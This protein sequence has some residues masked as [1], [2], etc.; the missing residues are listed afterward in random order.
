MRP[1]EKALEYIREKGLLEKRDVII[2]GVSGGADSMCMLSI[3]L[4]LSDE[5]ELSITVVH[6]N[7]GIRGE[8]AERDEGFVK[9]FCRKHDVDF[10]AFH[11]DIPGMAEKERLTLEEAGRRFRYSAFEK[12]A[13]EKHAGKVAVAHNLDDNAETVMFNIFRG[14]GLAGICGIRPMR[15][16]NEKLDNSPMLIRP[17]LGLSRREIEAY[18]ADKGMTY[19]T[20]ETNLQND[21]S[22]NRIRNIILPEAEAM[23]NGC[24]RE[25]LA[26][27]SEKAY[28]I[29]DYIDREAENYMACH[30]EPVENGLKT[31]AEALMGLHKAIRGIVIRKMIGRLS[32][33]LKDVEGRHVASVERLISESETGR[34]CDLPYGIKAE[35]E[36]GSLVMRKPGEPAEMTVCPLRYEI[37]RYSSEEGLP[38]TS[39]TKWFDYDKIQ[40]VAVLRHRQDGDF[41]IIDGEGHRKSLNRFFIDSKVP[42]RKRDALWLLAEGNHILYV[43][44]MRRDNSCLVDD[45]TGNIL[46]LTDTGMMEAD[47]K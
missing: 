8:S 44:G 37:R 6:V 42:E 41:L 33:S 19:C 38:K 21:Y 24:V 12:T 7:H 22:R 32:H 34:K 16:L 15:R 31:E 43:E 14:S 3:L 46:E 30:M 20:D 47:C 10:V 29:G 9:E 36:Y 1:E 25:H 27:L 35:T 39:Y 45:T 18:L 4:E 11:A 2:A 13:A 23:F 40:N 5:L 17:V 28:D 26:E